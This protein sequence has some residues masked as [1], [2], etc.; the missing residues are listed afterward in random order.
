MPGK[1]MKHNAQPHITQDKSRIAMRAFFSIAGKWHLDN[2]QMQALLGFPKD[3]TFFNWKKGEV[4][5][6][7]FDTI[8][9]ISYIL[10]IYKALEILY[11]VPSEADKWISKPNR[12]FGGQSAIERMS[13]GSITDI[14][15]VRHYLDS[16]RGGH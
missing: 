12:A 9:R 8:E 5:T 13:A 10:G 1:Q 6:V 11:L 2:A 14:A 3:A 16:V 7:P 4:K 15:A